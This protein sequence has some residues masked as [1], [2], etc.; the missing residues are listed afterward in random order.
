M[1]VGYATLQ[2]IP[3]LKGVDKAIKD[4][5]GPAVGGAGAAAGQAAGRGFASKFGSAIAS[6]AS[7]AASVVTSGLS[8][9]GVAGGALF[10]AALT[11]G[12]SRFTAIEDATASLTV[13]L[14]DSAKA[15][16]LLQGVLD[17]VRG[18]PFRLDQ[19]ATAAQRLAGMG[20]EAQKIPHFLSAIGNAAATQG[21][22]AEE[23]VSRLTRVFGQISSQGRI[24]G[25]DLLQISETGVN[26]LAI[27]G[28]AFGKTSEEM[29][30]M[31]S[32]GAVPAKEALDI[33]ADGILNGSTGVAGATVAFGGQMEVLGST[34]SGTI[35]NFGA[36][37]GRFG[38]KIISPIAPL[39][40][41][42]LGAGIEFL[43][44]L[45][46]KIA[47]FG[48]TL[49]GRFPAFDRFFQFLADSGDNIGPLVS[50]LA[51]LAPALAPILGIAGG[52]GLSSIGS[53]LGP[54]GFL[55]PA[56][57]PL[58]GL[59]AG[60]VASSPELRD[61]LQ[62]VAEAALP[63]VGEILTA[64]APL[65]EELAPLATA[66]ADA[67]GGL[68]LGALEGIAPIVPKVVEFIQAL[69]DGVVELLPAIVEV[70]LALLDGFLPVLEAALPIL[71]A[72][73]PVIVALATALAAV[74]AA[75]P[76]GVITGIVAG[77]LAFRGI[78]AAVGGVRSLHTEMGKVITKAGEAR[79]K[80][81]AFLNASGGRLAGA[82]NA[83]KSA[84]GSVG[85]AIRG[86][87]TAL[88]GYVRSAAV[89]TAATARAV[90]AWIA[91][92]VALVAS[93]IAT[94]AMTVAQTALNVVMALNPIVLVVLAIG[95]LIAA[96][97]LAY[98]NIEVFRNIVDAAF[99]FILDII[100]GVWNWVSDHWPL[101]L[102]IL[103]GPIGLA[104]LFI[105]QHWESIKNGASAVVD[106]VVGFFTAL[107]GRLA[108]FISS[109]ASK[110]A[111]MGTAFLDGLK[112][113][114]SGAAGFAADVAGAL[115][116]ALKSAWNSFARRV[117]GIIPNS[118]GWGPASID[119]P[120][121]PIP[122]FHTGGIFDT[123]NRSREGLALLQKGEGVFTRDQM[124]ALGLMANAGNNGATVVIDGSGLDKRL[125]EW[126][127]YAIRAQGGDV[128]IV[129]GR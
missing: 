107:P 94:G 103:T 37:L 92:K 111:E 48:D 117:N 44:A 96:V 115:V 46:E 21:G 77:F 120:D 65:L 41:T 49:E 5:L 83:V 121:N 118:L 28:N 14:G 89:A 114:V 70:G 127:R 34:L 30:D 129:L 66:L 12:F 17:T 10:G 38:E 60:L 86:A 52:L 57:G 122:T 113:V 87:A 40:K 88:A 32:R 112:G 55:I 85:G 75:V 53:A 81:S 109:M 24:M 125:L 78:S 104:V 58:G 99:R 19:F 63:L 23:F 72:L 124:S 62:G 8:A 108:G 25:Q 82:F 51:D 84:A 39:L 29:R 1:N 71:I 13:T 36:A 6:V 33:L 54:L 26:P 3:S 105:T 110:G 22:N 47:A 2:V 119:L 98:Q 35:G 69:A 76:P 100:T 123:G 59:I 31:V 74:V 56:I 64:L 90:A 67:V 43:D 68:L 42:G 50:K 128:Q 106:A 16:T 126:L 45:G 61:A 95:A 15:G 80:V 97:V 102:A 101:L 4:Q 18:T 7:S 91:Q 93:T 11:K 20:I 79:G 27:L 73:T 9:A 116:G